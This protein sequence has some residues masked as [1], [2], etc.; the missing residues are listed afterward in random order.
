M[1]NFRNTSMKL[2]ELQEHV[3][4]ICN[5][6][7]RTKHSQSISESDSWRKPAFLGNINAN[8]RREA[9][10]PW[11]VQISVKFLALKLKQAKIFKGKE[12]AYRKLADSVETEDVETLKT[13]LQ[14]L[15]SNIKEDNKPDVE[16]HDARQLQEISTADELYSY[17]WEL[18]EF[19]EWDRRRR[20]TSKSTRQDWAQCDKCD[21]W[22]KVSE[23]FRGRD[24]SCEMLPDTTCATPEECY[25][26]EIVD[27]ADHRTHAAQSG[28]APLP[29][30]VHPGG[31]SGG[32]QDADLA[33]RVWAEQR[34]L[35]PPPAR[36]KTDV[37]PPPAPGAG[38]SVELGVFP[39]ASVVSSGLFEASAY[40]APTS[41]SRRD[42][43]SSNQAVCSQKRCRSW[44][45]KGFVSDGDRA[46][47]CGRS[48]CKLGMPAGKACSQSAYADPT[49]RIAEGGGATAP[50]PA[51]AELAPMQQRG[52][53]TSETSARFT[54]SKR[55][56]PEQ[57]EVH[58]QP[59]VG[60]A[61]RAAGVQDRCAIDEARPAQDAQGDEIGSETGSADYPEKGSIGESIVDGRGAKGDPLERQKNDQTAQGAGRGLLALVLP[62]VSRAS[63]PARECQVGAFNAAPNNAASNSHKDALQEAVVV[64]AL[65]KACD[66][67][68]NGNGLG[69]P[70][71][72]GKT[73]VWREVSSGVGSASEGGSTTDTPRS[74][75]TLV[76][77]IARSNPDY[78]GKG[79]S[80]EGCVDGGNEGGVLGGAQGGGST[81]SGGTG[82]GGIG[83]KERKGNE[84]S[85]EIDDMETQEA[86][87]VLWTA[88]RA[89]A[90]A[91]STSNSAKLEKKMF[92]SS[93]A[94]SVRKESGGNKDIPTN[95]RLGSHE[96]EEGEEGQGG[97]DEYLRL[98]EEDDSSFEYE[99]EEGEVGE[100]N[101]DDR[102]NGEGVQGGLE[103]TPDEGERKEEKKKERNEMQ[104]AGGEKE[105]MGESGGK[106][107]KG[108]KKRA[109]DGGG[110]VGGGKAGGSVGR[111]STGEEGGLGGGRVS[112][113]DG[114]EDGRNPVSPK[115]PVVLQKS[116]PLQPLSVLEQVCGTGRFH[117][118][119][120]TYFLL[121]Y[122]L[123][124]AASQQRQ[125]GQG[126][127]KAVPHIF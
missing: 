71:E 116:T 100:V 9:I 90:S 34:G 35:P 68:L 84:D 101:E 82:G 53:E 120:L 33:D 31:V 58:V 77:E 32:L 89:Q 21:K 73:E 121:T 29:E 78:A 86:E 57:Q 125:A 27:D 124:L 80:I 99:E 37:L 61:G 105:E 66:F 38:G 49:T 52:L 83:G 69:T 28:A 3:D 67:S 4:E 56:K 106:G 11:I 40:S 25:D 6:L 111:G 88:L 44:R 91:C 65:L 7:Q 14:H 60:A 16:L 96:E 43:L 50:P 18:E 115:S 93:T 110:E 46:R 47:W 102:R 74:I 30:P 98:L 13:L 81:A 103:G 17:G 85:S 75:D 12:D 119:L 70:E 10:T 113:Q 59:V 2:E 108:T 54:S 114:R 122:E 92:A 107:Q 87:L 118:L 36:T 51:A 5:L 8:P 104:D 19:I 126:E 112:E 22:R 41:P 94:N 55:H 15:E 64:G 48:A 117:R 123:T 95:G 42:G 72:E 24:F 97:G 26:D 23:D 1:R 20:R 45:E 127:V 109:K 62:L 63:D 76:P 79:G 39:L